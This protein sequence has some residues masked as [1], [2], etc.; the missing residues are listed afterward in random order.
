MALRTLSEELRDLA[1]GSPQLTEPGTD[2]PYG[3]RLRAWIGAGGMAAVLRAERDPEVESRAFSPGAPEQLAIK[4][5]LPRV[6]REAAA[7]NLTPT[8]FFLREREALRRLMAVQ[9]PSEFVVGYYGSGT[10]TLADPH[11]AVTVPWLALEHVPPD[12][13]GAT[14]RDRVRSARGGLAPARALRLARGLLEGTRALHA[15]G[16]LHRD[17]KPENVLVVGPVDDETPKIADYGIARVADAGLS[18]TIGAGTPEYAAPEQLLSRTGQKNPLLGPWTDVHALAG[19]LWFILAGEDPCRGRRDRG[20]LQGERRSLATAARVH[21]GLLF[22]PRLFDELDKLLGLGLAPR[23]PR[24][25]VVSPET[26]PYVGDAQRF[27]PRMLGGDERLA[28]VEELAGPFLKTLTAITR[29]W[30]RRCIAARLPSTILRTTEL[31]VPSRGFAHGVVVAEERPLR[32]GKTARGTIDS[33]LAAFRPDGSALARLGEELHFLGARSP[34][35]VDVPPGLRAAMRDTRAILRGPTQGFSLVTPEQL[36]LL[37]HGQLSV[38]ASPQHPDGGQ[39]GPIQ[40]AA[41]APGA[42][43]I[44]TAETDDERGGPELWLC[45]DGVS[46]SEPRLLP[47]GGEVR[48]LAR[49]PYGWLVVGGRKTRGRALFL[50]DQGAAQVLVEGVHTQGPLSRA[51]V[52]EDDLWFA[53]GEGFVLALRDNPARLEEL[54]GARSEVP[55]AMELDRLGVPWLVTSHAVHRRSDASHGAR[56]QLVFRRPPNRPPFVAFSSI[57]GGPRILDAEGTLIL[58]RNEARELAPASA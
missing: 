54:E 28:S 20:W 45:R 22:E 57:A 25:A 38:V 3:V 46:W 10:C 17:L 2:I 14:L 52:T 42:L 18:G 8:D 13:Q 29:A 49:G 47:L 9:P 24:R 7:L 21:E 53:A 27:L 44:V 5:L 37:A 30:E 56:W 1:E 35:A 58:L 23:P 41:W 11:G 31:P 19:V 26:G 33:D 39:V 50:P 6:A 32:R 36:L 16:I 55:V 12:E 40:A 4:I 15:A 34:L 43:A 48:S 51:L